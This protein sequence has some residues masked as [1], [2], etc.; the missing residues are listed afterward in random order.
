MVESSVS[1][2]ETFHSLM[3]VFLR[4]LRTDSRSID[5]YAFL[6]KCFAKLQQSL[7]RFLIVQLM[8]FSYFFPSITLQQTLSK[9]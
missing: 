5:L 3:F 4:D 9:D 1:T 6:Q 7:L 2:L 8:I